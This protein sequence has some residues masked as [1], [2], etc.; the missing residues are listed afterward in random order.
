MKLLNLLM[1]I[2]MLA[3]KNGLAALNED[4][5]P[6]WLTAKS[7]LI[8][9]RAEKK[10]A[11][12]NADPA[13][14]FRHDAEL[15][16]EART[17]LGEVSQ[18]CQS[19][20]MEK[21]PIQPVLDV[22]NHF[23]ESQSVTWDVLNMLYFSAARQL[24]SAPLSPVLEEFEGTES[25][26]NGIE[27]MLQVSSP[28]HAAGFTEAVTA[29]VK[30][31]GH[32][33]AL[34]CFAEGKA[35]AVIGV[36]TMLECYV[37][38]GIAPVVFSA[39]SGSVHGGLIEGSFSTA[40]H[41]YLHSKAY[42]KHVLS[43]PFASASLP[44]VKAHVQSLDPHNPDH[45]IMI[46]QYHLM[47]HEAVVT[48]GHTRPKNLSALK[49]QILFDGRTPL[50]NDDEYIRLRKPAEFDAERIATHLVNAVM[51]DPDRGHPAWLDFL[52]EYG[53]LGPEDFV[54][55]DD[56]V[57]TIDDQHVRVQCTKL[58]IDFEAPIE[59]ERTVNEHTGTSQINLKVSLNFLVPQE[60]SNPV[61]ILQVIDTSHFPVGDQELHRQN[62]SD[63]AWLGKQLGFVDKDRKLKSDPLSDKSDPLSDEEM[64]DL[65]D[66]IMAQPH[67][68]LD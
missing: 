33:P 48:K 31:S 37:T 23:E 58:K 22:L 27:A 5:G 29:A 61:S 56:V 41:D 51:G 43:E 2:F 13:S 3:T 32:M 46:V 40:L 8:L 18:R 39:K 59:V 54:T 47:L 62:M 9:P 30:E 36:H 52:R 4:R 57:V 10:R 12:L 28:E 65:L 38:H 21:N 63:Y 53:P 6:L 35:S 55:M 14:R 60:N 45:A 24:D 26:M 64:R 15:V 1:V 7:S 49:E 67:P 68:L 19:L 50:M 20:G 11:Q 44:A 66:K 16:E 25:V 34:V 17:V 42:S